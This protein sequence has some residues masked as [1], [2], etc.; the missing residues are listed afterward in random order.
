MT[1]IEVCLSGTYNKV[2]IRDKAFQIKKDLKHNR[3]CCLLLFYNL[4]N[5]I[6]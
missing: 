3:R 4:F 6:P 5:T 2:S 1:T